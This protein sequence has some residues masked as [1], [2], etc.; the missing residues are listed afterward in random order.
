MVAIGAVVIA[1]V[2]RF[3]ALWSAVAGLGGVG[4]ACYAS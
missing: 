4:A 1:L 3:G 2:L